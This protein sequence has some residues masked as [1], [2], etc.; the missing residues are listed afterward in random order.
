MH[1]ACYMSY[2]VYICVYAS[3][4]V[5]SLNYLHVLLLSHEQVFLVEDMVKRERKSLLMII[6]VIM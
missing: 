3:S 5:L 6:L 2:S 1:C 4:L